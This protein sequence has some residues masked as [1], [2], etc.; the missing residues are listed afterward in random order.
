MLKIVSVTVH[1]VGMGSLANGLVI[2]LTKNVVLILK[3]SL[4][5]YVLYMEVFGFPKSFLILTP[6]VPKLAW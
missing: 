3:E 5:I 2:T 1:Q 6:G 4:L